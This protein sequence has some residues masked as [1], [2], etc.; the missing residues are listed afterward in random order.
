MARR[1]FGI[2]SSFASG[3]GPCLLISSLKAPP[4]WVIAKRVALGLSSIVL[5]GVFLWLALRGISRRDVVIAVSQLS[6]L[7]LVIAVSIYLSSIALRCLRWGILLRANGYV[8]WRHV[9]E[10]LIAGYAA[11][12]ILPA[13]LGELFR[14]D[15]ARRLFHISRF[16]WGPFWSSEIHNQRGA[17]LLANGVVYITWASHSD[18]GGFHGWIMGI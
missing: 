3:E 18:I 6:S 10:A 5:G 16:R 12:C 7:W 13:R 4:R 8:N 15:Y 1:R 17:L 14:A 9:A 11:N 2:S